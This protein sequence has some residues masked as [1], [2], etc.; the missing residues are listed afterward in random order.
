MNSNIVKLIFTILI[1]SILAS[2]SFAASMESVDGAAQRAL[3]DL[4]N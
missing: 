4:A 1:L 2:T 3:D